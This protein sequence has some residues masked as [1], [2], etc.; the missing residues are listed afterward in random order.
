[1]NPDAVDINLLGLDVNDP[2]SMDDIVKDELILP[3]GKMVKLR[4]RSRDVLHSALLPHFRAQMY[5][6]PGTPTQFNLTPLYTTEEFRAKLNKPEFNFELACNQICG[7]S[8]YAMKREIIVVDEGEYLAW[9]SE[10]EPMFAG[11]TVNTPSQ[12]TLK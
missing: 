3:K 10:Q 4:M 6:V 1:M 8:H 2:A 11:K 7:A 12:L 9:M 5:C